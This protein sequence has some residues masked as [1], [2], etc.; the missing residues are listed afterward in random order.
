M[1]E[2]QHI[3]QIKEPIHDYFSLSYANYLVLPRTVLQSMPNEWQ[4]KFVELLEEI[5]EMF[6]V[7]WEPK[8]GYRVLALNEDKHF[9]KDPYSNYERGRR[10][11]NF[12]NSNARTR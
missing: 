11:L 1:K 12:V 10:K 5:P 7:D 6:G 2:T 4:E 8:G 9:I 3:L